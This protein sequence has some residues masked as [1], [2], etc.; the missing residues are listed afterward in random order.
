MLAFRPLER[1]TT[2]SKGPETLAS[3][4]HRSI[5]WLIT[6]LVRTRLVRVGVRVGIFPVLALPQVLKPYFILE[7][8]VALPN[9]LVPCLGEF[10]N[11]ISKLFSH[12]LVSLTRS[13][14]A[15]NPQPYHR[16]LGDW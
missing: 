9:L 3:T 1:I 12:F 15:R 7:G 6:L 2:Q 10:G 16:E 11:E 8:L 5:N 4:P 14:P 13:S